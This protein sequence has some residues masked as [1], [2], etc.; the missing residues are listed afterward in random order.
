MERYY[1][2]FGNSEQ[3]P[4]Q[5]TYLVVISSDRM[6]ALQAFREKHPDV[7]EGTFNFSSQFSEDKWPEIWKKHYEG[8]T[9]AEILWSKCFGNVP[10]GFGD[11]YIFVP[12]EKQIVRI[13]EGTGD[14]LLPE[15]TAAGYVDYIMYDQYYLDEGMQEVDGGQLM[16]Y[17]LVQEK[18]KRL[19]DSMPDVLE[20]AYGYPLPDCMILA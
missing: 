17:Q 4:Y 14:N 8:Q 10:E 20:M 12:S 3:F 19:A 16:T 7:N 5:N 13:S 9:P 18:Y 1:F 2:T 15:D 11:V 6:D